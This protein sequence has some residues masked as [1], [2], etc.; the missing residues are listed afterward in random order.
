MK[1][2]KGKRALVTGA[3]SGIGLA[4]AEALASRG[5]NLVLVARSGDKLTEIAARLAQQYQVQA[6]V[7]AL[8]LGQVGAA[9]QVFEAVKAK[10]WTIDLL[11][12]NA[13]YG[14]WGEFLEFGD[15]EYTSM[16]QLNVATL[17]ELCHEFLPGLIQNKGLGI[18]NVGST[19]S[20]LPV[21]YAAVYSASKAFVLM[22][23]EALWGEYGHTGVHFMTLCP[24]ATSTQFAQ[25]ANPTAAAKRGSFG[26]SP[27]NV[28]SD[29]L[30][31]FEK[32]QTYVVS[33]GG[34]YFNAAVLPRLLPRKSVIGI[35]AGVFRKTARG[36]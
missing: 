23:T 34:N 28:V 22:F 20:L 7:L 16:L 11:I 27:G 30:A 29:A 19:A 35:V 33:G 15:A 1:L 9:H 14:K 5:L 10:S 25:V 32:G 31:A 6:D 4:F 2:L 3:S 8:D 24:G 26:D 12:N 18:I 21:P 17:V 13:G 36:E